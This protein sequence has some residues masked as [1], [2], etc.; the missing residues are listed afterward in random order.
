[1]KVQLADNKVMVIIDPEDIKKKGDEL[2]VDMTDSEASEI[3]E[4]LFIGDDKDEDF[5]PGIEQMIESAIFY[6]TNTADIDWNDL[7]ER[8]CETDRKVLVYKGLVYNY[9]LNKFEKR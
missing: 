8:Q 7:E 9:K 5:E 2:S 3:L 4:R 6:E 1:M